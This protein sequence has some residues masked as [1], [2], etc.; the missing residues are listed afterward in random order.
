MMTPEFYI[1]LKDQEPDDSLADAVFE[2]GFDDSSFVM[3]SGHAAIWVT[4]R[5]GDLTDLVREALAQ[6]RKGGLNVLHVEMESE[7]FA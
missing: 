6:A 5:E 1:I 2:A 7:V 3:R 4:D